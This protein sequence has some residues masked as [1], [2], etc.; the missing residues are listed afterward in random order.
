MPSGSIRVLSTMVFGQE[1][2]QSLILYSKKIEIKNDGNEPYM[3]LQAKPAVMSQVADSIQGM[4]LSFPNILDQ[5][6]D[7]ITA[8]TVLHYL[9]LPILFLL[10]K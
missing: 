8:V 1:K 4:R 10:Y 9:T 7:Q 2:H 3:Y 5:M 6:L